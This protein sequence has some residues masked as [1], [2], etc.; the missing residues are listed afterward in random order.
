MNLNHNEYYI[1]CG[2]QLDLSFV[3]SSGMLLC[4]SVFYFMISTTLL[5]TPTL[6]THR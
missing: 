2:L 4:F 6:Y 3:Q 5:A 1:L